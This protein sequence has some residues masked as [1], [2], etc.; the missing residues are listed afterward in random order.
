MRA[1][2]RDRR[3]YLSGHPVL[4]ALLAAVRHRAVTRL[5]GTLLVN[6]TD[7]FVE[8]MTRVPLDRRADGTTGAIARDLADADLL[9]DQDGAAHRNARRDLAARLS[10]AGVERLRP[11]WRSVL[12]RRLGALRD[13]GRADL[14]DM[15]AELAGSTAAALLGI[16]ADPRE[17]SRAARTAA[18]AAARAHLPGIRL[19]A[20]RGHDPATA[21]RALTT[22]LAN[23]PRVARPGAG[24]PGSGC[25]V[26][27]ADAG[28]ETGTGLASMLAVAAINTTVAAIPRAVA[29]CADDRLWEHAAA[30]GERLD[31]LVSEL[32]RVVVPTPLLPRAA[33]GDGVIGGCPVAHGDRLILVTRHATGAHHRDPD[34]AD[35]APPHVAQLVF[36]T[37]PH[38]CPGA[39]LARAQLRDV[40][41]ALAPLHPAVVTARP[42]R[43]AALPGWR[44]LTIEATTRGVPAATIRTGASHPPGA[45]GATPEAGA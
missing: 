42:D 11:V 6:G 18:A 2:A 26:A 3:V 20:R 5:G 25:P 27:R 40:L 44:V 8:A 28:P 45:S 32:L 12:D 14:V 34:P 4:F 35:P 30:G 13:G 19:P 9:F 16:D 41:A 33:G 29:W 1:R 21:A 37:G 10:S 22:L 43:G 7:A 36:G 15:T 38:A 24:R 17:L 31:A 39:A 23:A